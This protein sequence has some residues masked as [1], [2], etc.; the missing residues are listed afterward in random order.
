MVSISLYGGSES[1]LDKTV[2]YFNVIMKRDAGI[3]IPL[4]N[5]PPGFS[6]SWYTDGNETEWAS[7]ETS[8]GEFATEQEAVEYF[9]RDY[10]AH[11]DELKRRLL[12]A[13]AKNGE[14]VG[15]ITS[16]WNYT[17]ERRDQSIHWL[18]VRNEY[19]GLG[20][21]KALVSECLKRL[22]VL[23]NERDVWLHTQT[24]S[25]KAIGLYLKTG[26]EFVECESFSDYKNDYD[27]AMPILKQV[28]SLFLR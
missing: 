19:Q 14:A 17:G 21:G 7:I 15:T 13:R 28:I 10:L 12:F 6:W 23:E 16:W 18:A 5:L 20:L 25:H 4:C 27:K 3:P 8:V 26:F 2:P 1:L 24:W 9:Q 22:V 11:E